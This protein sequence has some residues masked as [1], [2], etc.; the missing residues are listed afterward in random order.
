MP[1]TITAPNTLL[2]PGDIVDV[3]AP[4]FRCPPENLAG[5][6]DFL[7][8]LGLKPRVPADLFGDDLLCANSDARRLSLLKRALAARDS[9]AV[10]CVRGGYGAIRII[11]RL[12]ALTPPRN[13]KLFIG[14]SDAT[15]VHWLLNQHWKWPSLHGPLLD[16]LGNAAVPETEREE[17]QGVLFGGLPEVTFG[18]LEPLN[19]AARRRGMIKGSVCGG[20]LTV[21][22][23][24][25]GTPLQR[26]PRGLLFLEDVGERGYR[27]DRMLEQLSQAGLLRNL[28]AIVFGSFTGGR[29]A[30][31]SNLGPQV[32][33]RFAAGQKI[34]VLRGIQAGHG[35]YQ[36]PLFLRSPAR[37]TCGAGAALTISTP[38]FTGHATSRKADRA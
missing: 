8:R 30:D 3:V 11:E 1:R 36:R 29:E 33:E 21:L 27:I 19:A 28:D 10:W 2:A 18:D 37:L 14:Y 35:E 24:L 23:S 26:R 12:R 9:R 22:Q 32:L 20:N 16:R 34:P 38:G 25:L 7:R 13:P 31:G 6:I 17:L 4:G 15:T 5:G